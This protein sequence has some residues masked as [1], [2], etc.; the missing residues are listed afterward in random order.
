MNNNDKRNVLWSMANSHMENRNKCQYLSEAELFPFTPRLFCLT[1]DIHRYWIFVIWQIIFNKCENNIMCMQC[2][3]ECLGTGLVK[4]CWRCP[5]SGSICAALFH[6]AVPQLNKTVCR[7]IWNY[8]LTQE[9]WRI[10]RFNTGSCIYFLRNSGT[11][12]I[13]SPSLRRPSSTW[14]HAGTGR[15]D[16]RQDQSDGQCSRLF[17]VFVFCFV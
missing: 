9:D 12:I 15:Q 16:G 13:P 6:L 10:Y 3:F 17:F 14:G 5:Y 8:I 4:K 11:N 1:A 7:N 2:S